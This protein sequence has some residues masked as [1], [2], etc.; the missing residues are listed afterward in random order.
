V[1]KT[2]VYVVTH[3]DTSK[4]VPD[5]LM[6][7]KGVQ[8]VRELRPKLDEFLPEGPTEIHV[9]TGC[10][11]LQ[12][13]K[14]LRFAD[15]PFYVSDIWGGSATLYKITEAGKEIL[16]ADGTVILEKYY[17]SSQ[18][19]ASV[20]IFVICALPDRALIL[21]GRP[22]L[23]RLSKALGW[24]MPVSEMKSGALYA[25]RITTATDDDIDAMLAAEN[26]HIDLEL[27]VDGV[28]LEKG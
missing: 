18:F 12:V 24:N 19:F 15:Q 4:G 22:T 27:L 3:G 23:D 11:Q 16:L 2:T 6:T 7:E 20:I 13:L 5:P 26:V 8:Q 28:V 9:G 1:K 17:L 21:S 14:E 10:R 25:L